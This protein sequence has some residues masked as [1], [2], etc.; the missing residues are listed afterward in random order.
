[1]TP[2]LSTTME[3]TY[4]VTMHY[5]IEHPKDE[6]FNPNLYAQWLDAIYD[7]LHKRMVVD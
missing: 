4:F 3:W 2:Q 5:R 6:A 1:V 7:G